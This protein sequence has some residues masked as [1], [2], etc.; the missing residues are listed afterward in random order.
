LALIQVACNKPD[1]VTRDVQPER[2]SEWIELRIGASGMDPEQI[3]A[4]VVQPIE[5]AMSSTPRLRHVTSEADDAQARVWLEFEPGHRDAV[6][7]EVRERLTDL[8]P[9]L[10][11]ELD[12]PVVR[13]VDAPGSTFVRWAIESDTID[14]LALSKLHEELVDRIE[15]IAGVLGTQACAPQSRVVIEL[16]SDRLRAYGIEP[17]EIEAALRGGSIDAPTLDIEGLRHTVIAGDAE[18]ATAVRLGDVAAIRFGMRESTCVAA[19]AAGLVAAASVT[20]RDGSAGL[21]VEQRLDEL[22]ARLP[23]GVRLRRFGA[24][25]TTVELSVAADREL[26]EVAQSIGSGLVKLT[27]PWLVE[28]GVESDPCVGV[29]TRVRLTVVG[30]EP[31]SLASFESIPGVTHV[32][33]LGDP[34]KRRLWLLGPDPHALHEL[35]QREQTRLR[36]LPSLLAVDLYAEAPRVELRIDPDR[37]RLAELQLTTTEFARQLQLVHD[38]LEVAVLR[39]SNGAA[40]PVILRVGARDD[41]EPAQLGGVLIHAGASDVP[42][43][44]LDAIANIGEAPGP[45]RICRYD[46][47]RGVVFTLQAADPNA[48]PVLVSSVEAALPP[49][50]RWSWAD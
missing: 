45:A 34:G 44:R 9:T 49:G 27:Q 5:K 41:L 13:V 33:L 31:V 19:S 40:V 10:P 24:A 37:A 26:D 36:S 47:Q 50:Y 7:G 32:Q 39:D 25:D 48:W 14:P 43:V 8:V 46:G 42:P 23:E 15:V 1:V 21:A 29:G 16:D 38:G 18:L 4:Q 30:S 17:G 28:V 6:L 20:V 2:E 3:E 35:A 22:A 12:H 11:S